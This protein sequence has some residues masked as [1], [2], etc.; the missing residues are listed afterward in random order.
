KRGMESPWR[1]VATAAVVA[2]AGIAVYLTLLYRSSADRRRRRGKGGDKPRRSSSWPDEFCAAV[3]FV[4]DHGEDILDDQTRLELYGWFKQATVGDCD[5]DNAKTGSWSSA[6]YYMRKSWKAK[7]G[8]S[9]E[10]AFRRYIEVLEAAQPDWREARDE[11]DSDNIWIDEPEEKKVEYTRE[12]QVVVGAGDGDEPSVDDSPAG[13]FCQ[14]CA[15]GDI[16]KV[17]EVLS[18]HPSAARMVDADGMT[19]LHW[20]CDRSRL[21]VCRLLLDSGADVNAK[22]YAGE[23]PLS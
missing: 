20:A 14:L 10:E 17:Q 6:R 15:E 3:D 5:G 11:D 19:P 21:D 16:D 8:R 1:K 18:T 22:D 2:G 4:S 12:P 9:K 13:M 7:K 23:T